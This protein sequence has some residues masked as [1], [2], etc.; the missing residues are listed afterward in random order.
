MSGT[1]KGGL[2]PALD[3]ALVGC[4]DQ[5]PPPGASSVL[6]CEGMTRRRKEETGSPTVKSRL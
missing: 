6:T 5:H 4:D 1:P 2:C 3:G